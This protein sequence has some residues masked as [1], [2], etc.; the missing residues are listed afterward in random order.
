MI[1]FTLT[2]ES[3]SK[4]HILTVLNEH[5]VSINHYA[6]MFFQHTGF[7]TELSNE[8]RIA[9]TSLQEI[10][11]ES[12]ATLAEIARQIPKYD[13]FPCPANTGL[14]LRILWKDQP[15]SNNSILRGTHSA[16]DQAVTVYSEPLRQDDAFPKGL[17]LRNIDGRLWLRGY[18]C[19]AE[20]RF[21]AESLF[22]FEAGLKN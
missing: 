6:E 14:F 11:L 13:L 3:F 10:G 18:I 4:E 12:G 22:A 2:A 7:T 5:D 20:Y 8:R 19:D 1:L 15:Q 21:P 16:P 17:Y 9:I